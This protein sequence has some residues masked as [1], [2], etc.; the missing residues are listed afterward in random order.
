MFSSRMIRIK[1]N[2]NVKVVPTTVAT[3]KVFVAF[4]AAVVEAVS[5]AVE[6]DVVAVEFKVK[7]EVDAVVVMIALNVF[8]QTILAQCLGIKITLGRSVCTI[9]TTPILFTTEAVVVAVVAEETAVEEIL[10]ATGMVQ[11][12]I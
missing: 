1:E 11:I 4:V 9:L 2:A 6:V 12:F 7:V 3:T 5:M 8:K 10:E